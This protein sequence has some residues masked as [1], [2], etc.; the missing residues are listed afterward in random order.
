MKQLDEV[1]ALWPNAS[2][3]LDEQYA[4]ADK[5]IR[6]SSAILDADQMK[7]WQSEY[8]AFQETTQFD[9]QVVHALK[10]ESLLN[11]RPT[12]SDRGLTTPDGA[13]SNDQKNWNDSMTKLLIA[14]QRRLELESG[15][16]GKLTTES[17]RLKLPPI[18]RFR[19]SS[20]S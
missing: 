18:F 13:D 16:I 1:R 2:M 5:E 4:K 19:R 20:T 17:L 14:E 15:F 7:L 10:I 12:P 11:P 6:G 8:A 3:F 9:R